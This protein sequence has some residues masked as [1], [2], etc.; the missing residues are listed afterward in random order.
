VRTKLSPDPELVIFISSNVTVHEHWLDGM[1]REYFANKSRLIIP[2]TSFTTG[3]V[4]SGMIGS[5]S[6]NWVAADFDPRIKTAP[7][8]PYFSAVGVPSTH[9]ALL[10]F[11]RIS[12]LLLENRL[13]ELSL[14]AWLCGE[15]IHATPFSMVESRLAALPSYNWREHEG[16]TVDENIVRSCNA[17]RDMNWFF[18]KF[19]DYDPDGHGQLV[20]LRLSDYE[21]RTEMCISTIDATTLSIQVC[22]RAD[23]HQQFR[24][25]VHS[26]LIASV[27]RL[28]NCLDAGSATF[29]G[30]KLFIYSCDI[31]NRNQRF[32]MMESKI[33]WG[34]FCLHAKNASV[35][36]EYCNPT[37]AQNFSL[38]S[39]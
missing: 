23:I 20:M 2:T 11:E 16:E 25:F 30:Q 18:E 27:G 19:A 17:K 13:L 22:D 28:N 14:N 3:K 29:P 26:Q 6:G 10:S 21:G 7:L 32:E 24:R 37:V 15:G 9:F 8:I 33:R 39:I 1:V 4:M 5:V 38:D 12:I 31:F 34:S 35:F 36:L